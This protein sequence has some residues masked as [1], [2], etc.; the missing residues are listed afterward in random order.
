MVT[1]GGIKIYVTD[2]HQNY[3]I[4]LTYLIKNIQFN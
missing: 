1:L 4:K 2:N 3:L